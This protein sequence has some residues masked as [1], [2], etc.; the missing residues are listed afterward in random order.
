[1]S[2]VDRLRTL[3][4]GEEFVRVT[5]ESVRAGFQ[6]LS[7]RLENELRSTLVSV[8]AESDVAYLLFDIR[9]QCAFDEFPISTWTFD[10]EGRARD[11][12]LDNC[13]MLEGEYLLGPSG[14]YP[15]GRA[16]SPVG[17]TTRDVQLVENVM[18][19]ELRKRWMVVAGKPRRFSA[20]AGVWMTNEMWDSHP[21]EIHDLWTGDTRTYDF[22]ARELSR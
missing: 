5:E 14:S 1:M 6:R 22:L 8:E 17:D 9:P 12:A 7:A 4:W 21:S 20:L 19:D 13:R 15:L 2:F 16:D 10:A 11:S 3:V 18:L